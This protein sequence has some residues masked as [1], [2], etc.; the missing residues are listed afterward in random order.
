MQYLSTFTTE[1]YTRRLNKLTILVKEK[2]YQFSSLHL[3]HSILPHYLTHNYL[4][5]GIFYPFLLHT[6]P[7]LL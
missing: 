4:S 3:L 1:L 6:L 7:E 5:L 2:D